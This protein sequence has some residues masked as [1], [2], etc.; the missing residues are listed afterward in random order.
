ECIVARDFLHF[1]TAAQLLEGGWHGERIQQF[2]GLRESVTSKSA[3]SEYNGL[4]IVELQRGSAATVI[5][6]VQHAARYA[7]LIQIDQRQ[8]RLAIRVHEC[9]QNIGVRSSNHR[10]QF[11]SHMK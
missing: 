10:R 6:G 2:T 3:T 4:C 11:S 1:F 5:E 7:G 9:N 8:R